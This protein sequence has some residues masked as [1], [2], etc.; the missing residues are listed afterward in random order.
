M[1]TR[2]Q[3]EIEARQLEQTARDSMQGQ[4]AAS[5]QTLA[6]AAAGALPLFTFP[7]STV[8]LNAASEFQ[9]PLSHRM[10]RYIDA[11]QRPSGMEYRLME[12]EFVSSADGEPVRH[13]D[14]IELVTSDDALD[15]LSAGYQRLDEDRLAE[16]IESVVDRI[17]ANTFAEPANGE[18]LAEI[19]KATTELGLSATAKMRT[20]ADAIDLLEGRLEPGD[21]VARSVGRQEC[22]Q[23][24][25]RMVVVRQIT[26]STE[27]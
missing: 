5:D 23:A 25:Q 4:V 15:A 19:E 21:F 3:L 11:V 26:E 20:K 7:E 18:D 22:F 27:V 14:P 12:E 16:R 2:N 9:G 24:A 10:V 6:L 8:R 1:R 17:E 13:Y